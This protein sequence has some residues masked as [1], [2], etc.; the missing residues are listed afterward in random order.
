M[1][2]L[3]TMRRDGTVRSV[4]LAVGLLL[5]VALTAAMGL[6]HLWLWLEGYREVPVIGVLF[7]VNAICAAVLIVALLAMPARLRRAVA[8]TAALF[9]AGTLAS[10]VLSLTVGFLGVHELLQT[11]LVPAALIVESCGVLVLGLIALLAKPLTYR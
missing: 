2:V 5:A 1:N 10:L 4:L 11:P 6:I 8:A 3:A 7:L 9:T